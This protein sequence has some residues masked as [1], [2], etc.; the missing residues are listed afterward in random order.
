MNNSSDNSTVKHYSTG[1]YNSPDKYNSSGKYNFSGKNNF[2]EKYN[3]PGKNDPSVKIFFSDK[4]TGKRSLIFLLLTLA[5]LLS[6]VLVPGSQEPGLF[7]E[8]AADQDDPGSVPEFREFSEL[9]GRTVS[10]LTGAPF[11]ELVRSFVPDVGR[12]TYYASM[13]DMLLALKSGKTDAILNNNAVAALAVNKNSDLALFPHSLQDGVFGYAFAKGDPR[14]EEWQKA[15]DRIPEE[16]LEELWEKWTGMDESVKH[17]P[18]QDWP[19]ENGTVKVAMCDTLEPVSYVGKNREMIGFDIELIQMIARELDVHVSFTGMELASVLSSVQSGKAD[20]GGG[21]IIA[22]D[23]RKERMDCIEYYPTHFVLVVRAAAGGSSSASGGSTVLSGLLSGLRD[24]FY[25][26]FIR[27][28]RYRMV[29][30]GLWLTVLMSLSS[31][32]AGLVLAYL[33]VL[34]RHKDLRVTNALISVYEALVAGIPAVVILMVFYYVIFGKSSLPAV[35][36]A[37]IGFSL[38]FGARAYGTIWNAAAA[39]DDG[40]REAALALGYT[41]DMSFKRVILPQAKRI[42]APVLQSQFVSLLKETSVA[43]YIAVV[44]LTRAGDLI[45]SR[46]MEA[47]FPLVAIALIYYAL[48]RLMTKAADL[49]RKS[50]EKKREARKIKGVDRT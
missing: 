46:T 47:F 27:E 12:F 8:Q 28:S 5:F 39:V 1:K 11:E 19:G 32:A 13:A 4:K 45:R 34:L 6:A 43:G 50:A 24:S 23:E 48:T 40:Q 29:L 17:V 31:G 38:I 16:T 9:S 2:S 10:M 15:L 37:I 22:T 7:E 49:A 44:E 33:L 42:Y 41:T 25:R 3:S 18:E 30:S 26:T 35:A 14:R 36:V 21:S 20:L